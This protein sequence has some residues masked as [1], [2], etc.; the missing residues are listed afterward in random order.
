[1][2]GLFPIRP[3]HFPPLHH[4]WWSSIFNDDI[5]AVPVSL[6]ASVP[7]YLCTSSV[8]VLLCCCAT[9]TQSRCCTSGQWQQPSQTGLLYAIGVQCVISGGGRHAFQKPGFRDSMVQLAHNPRHD[10]SASMRGC[11]ACRLQAGSALLQRPTKTVT[12][13]YVAGCMDESLGRQA[14]V[15]A[16]AM[17]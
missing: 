17:R 6:C 15:M 2:R 7:L 8:P 16:S 11:N 3:R 13:S 5:S 12:P 9:T 4:T 10:A 14:L 1:M